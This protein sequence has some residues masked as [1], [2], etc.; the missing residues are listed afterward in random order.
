MRISNRR[1]P[2]RPKEGLQYVLAIVFRWWELFLASRYDSIG[3]PISFQRPGGA[4]RCASRQLRSSTPGLNQLFRLDVDLFERPRL[5]VSGPWKNKI[6]NAV[7]SP[8]IAR[9][10]T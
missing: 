6:K 10:G 3:A 1:A 2:R 4:L 7:S 9:I 5:A 8:A